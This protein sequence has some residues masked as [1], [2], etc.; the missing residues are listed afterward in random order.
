MKLFQFGM[1]LLLVSI[2]AMAQHGDMH[3]APA[4]SSSKTMEHNHNTQDRKSV[5]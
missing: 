4:N 1:T 5:V 2:Y 3:S